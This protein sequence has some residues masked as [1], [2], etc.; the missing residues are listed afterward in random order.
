MMIPPF[1]LWEG[2]PGDDGLPRA[3]KLAEKAEF[4]AK[5]FVDWLNTILPAGDLKRTG[6]PLTVEG[7]AS[8]SEKVFGSVSNGRAAESG[9]ASAAWSGEVSAVLSQSR[10]AARK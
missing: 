9:S 6:A 2:L 5:S 3:L 4:I 10:V 8:D 1:A 7:I